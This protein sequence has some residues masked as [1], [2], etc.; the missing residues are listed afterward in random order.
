MV[1]AWYTKTS[2]GKWLWVITEDITHEIMLK[3]AEIIILGIKEFLRNPWKQIHRDNYDC[4][5]DRGRED[6]NALNQMHF[7]SEIIKRIF[8]T[9]DWV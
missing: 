6:A 4:N 5:G 8:S 1:S 9:K 7:L 2:E 3:N